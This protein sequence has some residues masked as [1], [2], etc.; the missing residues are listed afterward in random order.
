[1]KIRNI[2]RL[3]RFHSK[4]QTCFTNL[5]NKTFNKRQTVKTT[6]DNTVLY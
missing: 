3:P 2:N 5:T 1:M 6:K 4:L